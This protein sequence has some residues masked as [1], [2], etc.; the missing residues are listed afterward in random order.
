M[1]R[2]NVVKIFELF[3]VRKP[4]THTLV[5]FSFFIP[6]AFFPPYT[7]RPHC[8]I[9]GPLFRP[10]TFRSQPLNDQIKRNEWVNLWAKFFSRSLLHAEENASF[11]SRKPKSESTA[12]IRRKRSTH[13]QR[14]RITAGGPLITKLDLIKKLPTSTR[15]A[16]EKK[17]KGEK[18]KNEKH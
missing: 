4:K 16:Q 8:S 17:K 1:L 14:Y 12:V 11:A 7:L 9:V 15:A 13:K 3:R 5:S 10:T 6:L 2:R 18:G